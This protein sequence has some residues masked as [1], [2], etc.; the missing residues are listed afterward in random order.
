MYYVDPYSRL[1]GKVKYIAQTQR[2]YT[3]L[4]TVAVGAAW[5]CV[6]NPAMMFCL[7][8]VRQSVVVEVTLASSGGPNVLRPWESDLHQSEGRISCSKGC[9]SD[10]TERCV[11]QPHQGGEVEGAHEH[12]QQDRLYRHG[13]LQ[14][15]LCQR[16]QE[17]VVPCRH[18]CP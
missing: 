13:Y 11:L 9:Y 16:S 18:F 10:L 4:V 7:T 12:A 6:S 14:D 3:A 15:V 17:P 2:A 8:S 5:R 1:P